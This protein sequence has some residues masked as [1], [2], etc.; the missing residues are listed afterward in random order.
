MTT[1][2]LVM[3]FAWKDNAL[4]LFQSTMYDGLLT[5]RRLRKRPSLTSTSAKTARAAFGDQPRAWK[6]IPDFSDAYNYHMGAVDHGDQLKSY[7]TWN[8]RSRSG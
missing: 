2:G 1:D 4:A 7:Y 8:G 6:S 5:T 3:Q